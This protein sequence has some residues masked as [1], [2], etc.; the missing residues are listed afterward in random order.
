MK[1]RVAV[2][3]TMVLETEANGIK[4]ILDWVITDIPHF[5]MFCHSLWTGQLLPMSQN[6]RWEHSVMK[7]HCK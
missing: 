2:E 7:I 4:P 5:W 3:D 6:Q 1:N